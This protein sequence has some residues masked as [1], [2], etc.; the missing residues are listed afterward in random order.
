VHSLGVRLE[1]MKLRVLA[2]RGR[3]R[4]GVE[5]ISGVIIRTPLVPSRF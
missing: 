2:R 1:P 3:G 5:P 4:H